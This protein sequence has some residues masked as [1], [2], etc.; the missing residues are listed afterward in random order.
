M[1]GNLEGEEVV[2]E[3]IT[4]TWAPED[5]QDMDEGHLVELFP[6]ES[7]QELVD[8]LS[9]RVRQSTCRQFNSF[10]L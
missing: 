2:V 4:T 10:K 1:V 3:G 7:V 5:L 9:L 8:T 6:E